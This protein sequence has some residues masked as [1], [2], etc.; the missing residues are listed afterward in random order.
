VRLQAVLALATLGCGPGETRGDPAS[1]PPLAVAS[2]SASLPP[3]DA[4][5]SVPSATASS[6]AT[7]AQPSAD[8]PRADARRGVF[9][10]EFGKRG[11]SA[12]R[13]AELVAATGARRVFIK[14]T[15]GR[16]SARWEGNASPAN[17]APFA[18]RGLE[19]WLFG[20]FYASPDADGIEWGTIDEQIRAMVKVAD[21][22]EV[23]GVLVDAEV[24]FKGKAAEAE[25]LCRGLRAALPS[26]QLAYTT[27][28]WLSPNKTFP[29][30]TFDRYCGDA[31]LPQVYWA[32]GWPGGVRAS[33]DRL[34]KDVAHLGLRAPVWPVQSNERDPAAADLELFFQLAGPDASVF[35]L[36]AE[37]TPQTEKL[38]R[39]SLGA[40]PLD[41]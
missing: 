21:R 39:I 33:L 29:Y 23:F 14:G 41:R 40:G 38:T 32:F 9:L 20:Y 34:R 8:A 27:F 6:A 1:E 35:Y 19:I 25:A 37:G 36:H 13:S 16:A 17:L 10:W 11:P 30:S 3:A 12:E 5:S 15:N 31:F 26:K 2:S 22:P 7:T 18:T 24:E 28:G 4:E